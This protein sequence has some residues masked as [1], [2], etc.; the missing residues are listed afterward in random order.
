MVD[1]GADFQPELRTFSFTGCWLWAKD[2]QYTT[3][4]IDEDLQM[5]DQQE[6][7]TFSRLPEP[8][9]TEPSVLIKSLH[10]TS[11]SYAFSY[12]T[13]RLSRGPQTSGTS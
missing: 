5:N 10:W 7:P 8:M 2:K 1:R 4:R 3:E 13:L 9:D 12:R 6:A 11:L